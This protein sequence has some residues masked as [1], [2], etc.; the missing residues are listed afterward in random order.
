MFCLITVFGGI[1]IWQKSIKVLLY[2]L[3]CDLHDWQDFNL[4]SSEKIAKSP[5]FNPS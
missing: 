5:K 1:L 3:K 4:A 2:T